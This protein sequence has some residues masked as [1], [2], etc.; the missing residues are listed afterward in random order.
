ML[1]VP[2]TWE[3]G[4]RLSKKLSGST[5]LTATTTDDASKQDF[6]LQIR[7]LLGGSKGV[8]S[9]GASSEDQCTK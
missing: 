4:K 2:A 1:Q 9:K 7:T 6:D 3:H 5:T 8:I